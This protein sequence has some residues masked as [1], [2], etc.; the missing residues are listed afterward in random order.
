MRYFYVFHDDG[1]TLTLQQR[2][3]TL[4]NIAWYGEAKDPKKGPLTVL[5]ALEETTKDWSNVLD[6][7]YK[8][9]STV[10]LTNSY[11]GCNKNNTTDEI[12]CLSNVYTLPER[13]GKARMITV[14]EAVNLGCKWTK[15]SCPVWMYNYLYSSI[16]NGGTVKGKVTS[17][18]TMNVPTSDSST[19]VWGIHDNGNLYYGSYNQTDST[20][21]GVRAVVQIK[22]NYL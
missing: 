4:D 18:W 1:D 2:E 6:Q 5:A 9:G 8:M 7:T 19:W 17:Y 10:F 14:Q 16:T 22:K 11:T 3:N 12:N 21:Y 15:N 13:T 20:N